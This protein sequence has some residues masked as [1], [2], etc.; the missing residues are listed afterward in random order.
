MNPLIVSPHVPWFARIDGD[1]LVVRN[2]VA[3]CGAGLSARVDYGSDETFLGVALPVLGRHP[4]TAGSPL[5]F[6]VP[7]PW[8]TVV[9]V[10]RE[11]DGEDSALT[12]HLVG[13][14]PDVSRWPTH[15]LDMSEA[16]VARFEP[17]M[18][19]M[20]QPAGSFWTGLGFSY[21][22]HGVAYLAGGL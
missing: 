1:D 7:I 10:W 12:C 16:L 21:R 8:Q 6:P 19:G 11:A 15:A 13:N 18:K 4:A 17:A 2:I 5:A 20:R 22:V 14:G 3:T 9:T